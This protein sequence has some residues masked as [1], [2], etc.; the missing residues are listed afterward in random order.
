MCALPIY[1]NSCDVKNCRFL[2]SSQAS[3]M[4]SVCVCVMI[5]SG[6]SSFLNFKW[7]NILA[8]NNQKEKI[9]LSIAH[10]HS[11]IENCFLFSFMKVV[12]VCVCMCA[13]SRKRA[14][15]IRSI[16]LQLSNWHGL[17]HLVVTAD[18]LTHTV[19]YYHTVT[20]FYCFFLAMLYCSSVNDEKTFPFRQYQIK[21]N[22]SWTLL[23]QI[24]NPT[25]GKKIDLQFQWRK[26]YMAINTIHVQ[27]Y[28]IIYLR[29]WLWI[30]RVDVQHFGALLKW[31]GCFTYHRR[32]VS[33]GNYICCCCHVGRMIWTRRW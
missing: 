11:M 15:F 23:A 17:W 30:C 29:D 3:K 8:T 27:L 4:V 21:L 2:F 1:S 7:W 32:M 28:I 9:Q 13:C 5:R 19:Y 31:F 24:V 22:E 12:R 6:F 18:T 26:I 25:N 10:T 20:T 14:E 33:I 16:E